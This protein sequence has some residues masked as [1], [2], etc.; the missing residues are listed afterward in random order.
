MVRVSQKI[1]SDEHESAAAR[2]EVFDYVRKAHQMETAEDYV[3]M[4]ADLIATRGEARVVDLAEN[5]GVSH[6]TVNKIIARLN[7]EGFVTNRPYRALFLTE[8]GEALAR[9]CKERHEV[10]FKFL[11]AIG[12]DERTAHL[13]AEGV[14]HHVSPKTLSAFRRFLKKSGS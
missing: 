13:D 8:E 2:A 1:G 10:V 3:E 12:V 9:E 7:R 14:E 5:F 4:I 11:R 6:A